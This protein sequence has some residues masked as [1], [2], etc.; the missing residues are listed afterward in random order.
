MHDPVIIRT[1]YAGIICGDLRV[2]NVWMRDAMVS[3]YTGGI[4]IFQGI[5]R[6][7]VHGSALTSVYN[8]NYN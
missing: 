6:N 7:K 1:Y 4:R 8:L 5:V 3:L 2:K